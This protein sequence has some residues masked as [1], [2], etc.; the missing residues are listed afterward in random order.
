MK[1]RFESVGITMKGDSY[2]PRK[3][4]EKK[5]LDSTVNYDDYRPVNV[6]GLQKMGKSSLLSPTAVFRSTR[7]NNRPPTPRSLP[8][9][10]R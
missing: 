6:V 8:K 7:R 2:V 3:L 9:N 4:L 1:N 5:L 10:A